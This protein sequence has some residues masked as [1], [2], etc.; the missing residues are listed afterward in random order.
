MQVV[1]LWF[2]RK[3]VRLLPTHD[4]T[5]YHTVP[6]SS[7]RMLEKSLIT[8]SDVIIYD[9]EDSVPPSTKDKD[10]ARARL[11]DFLGVCSAL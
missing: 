2:V 6:T 11:A 1:S 5:E 7:D 8:K 4:T 9:L 10:A 3:S